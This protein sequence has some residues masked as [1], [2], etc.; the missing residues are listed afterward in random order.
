MAISKLTPNWLADPAGTIKAFAIFVGSAP[1]TLLFG[2]V[3]ITVVMP[4]ELD[5]SLG[6][7]LSILI[8]LPALALGTV[9]GWT[10][11]FYG[12]LPDKSQPSPSPQP[13]AAPQSPPTTSAEL[14]S[15]RQSRMSR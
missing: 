4:M 3:S 2:I 5:T 12:I 1:V 8:A 14:R 15:L 13:S 7:S 9:L 10:A 6:K 11:L